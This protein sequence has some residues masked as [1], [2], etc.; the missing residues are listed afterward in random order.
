VIDLTMLLFKGMWIWGLWKAVKCFQWGLMG[1]PS[2]Y[3]E[4]FVAEGDLNCGNLT[5]KFSVVNFNRL[6]RDCS[7][8]ILVKNV[9]GL[10]SFLKS[11]LR[12]K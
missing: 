10:C 1:Y 12:L 11:L 7:C 6:P 3:M 5:P 2:R 9:A 8:D 4:D